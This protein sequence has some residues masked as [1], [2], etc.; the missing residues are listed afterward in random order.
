MRRRQPGR[1]CNDSHA[2]ALQTPSMLECYRCL[3]NNPS[4]NVRNGPTMKHVGDLFLAAA[5]ALCVLAAGPAAASDVSDV[6]ATIQK[7]VADFNRGDM[8][9]FLAACAPSVSVVD[10]FPPY[11]WPTCSDWMNAYRTNNKAIQ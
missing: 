3:R 7:W 8:K 10:G 5:C 11:A 6:A 1:L 9:S 4:P 2:S